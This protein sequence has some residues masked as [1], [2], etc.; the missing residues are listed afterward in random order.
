M[1]A[2]IPVHR[3]THSSVQTSI[4]LVHSCVILRHRLLKI[5]DVMRYIGLADGNVTTYT[6]IISFDRAYTT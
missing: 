3:S 5:L 2:T 6:L 1:H 4:T